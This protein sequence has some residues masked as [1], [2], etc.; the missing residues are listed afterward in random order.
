M[1][2]DLPSSANGLEIKGIDLPRNMS[3]FFDSIK[4]LN[5]KNRDIIRRK[6]TKDLS[7]ICIFVI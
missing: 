2:Q 3:K 1:L 5:Q 7:K 6:K 4:N